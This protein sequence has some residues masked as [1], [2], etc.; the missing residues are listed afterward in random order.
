VVELERGERLGT[1]KK[2]NKGKRR[3]G[4][5][6]KDKPQRGGRDLQTVEEASFWRLLTGGRLGGPESYRGSKRKEKLRK[7]QG[8][9]GGSVSLL[10]GS[11]LPNPGN[12]LESERTRGKK[13]NQMSGKKKDLTA[14]PTIHEE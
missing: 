10:K 2:N 4:G 5:E 12:K 11:S 6:R 3:G 14:V 9:G 7:G 1:G 8:G 13:R